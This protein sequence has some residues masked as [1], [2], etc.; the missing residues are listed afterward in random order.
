VGGKRGETIFTFV[1]WKESFKRNI[2]PI[3]I[4]LGTNISCMMGI[5][6]YSNEVQVLF[7]GGDNHNS[8]KIG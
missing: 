8:V 2:W 7:K 3:S 6:V 1:Y 5:E 4:K